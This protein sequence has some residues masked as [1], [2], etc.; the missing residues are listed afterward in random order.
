MK[1][2]IFV[3]SLTLASLTLFAQQN[4]GYTDKQSGY[5]T[6][7]FWNNWFLNVGGGPAF[8]WAGKGE[9]N[10]IDAFAKHI[11]WGATVS[12]GKWFTP[13]WGGRLTVQ[14]GMYH[15]FS[16]N[17]V[18]VLEGDPKHKVASD[19][20]L[21]IHADGL[22][23]FSN[24]VAGYK[25]NR[26][27]N[28]IPY[29]GVGIGGNEW[30]WHDD[31]NLDKCNKSFVPVV[32][33][34]NSFRLGKRVDFNVDISGQ[35]VQ[36]KWNSARFGQNAEVA[37][38][39]TGF[40]HQ[41]WDGILSVNFGFTFKLGKQDF[42]RGRVCPPV[43]NDSLL[44][45]NLTKKVNDLTAENN[46]LKNQLANQQPVAPV[47]ETPKP[48]TTKTSVSKI[49]AIPFE[50]NKFQVVDSKQKSAINDAV[51]FLKSNPDTDVRVVGYADK[52]TGTTAINNELSRKRADEVT[53]KLIS[54]GISKDRISTYW[55][56]DDVQ[57]YAENNQNRVVIITALDCVDCK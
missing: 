36:S 9:S 29:I 1:K 5:E 22:F 51:A 32:G 38:K 31:A 4:T 28:L 2:T 24:W 20:Y 23:N 27:Y 56:G 16:R 55:K 17:G 19:G 3:F 7:R 49:I 8:Y 50:L 6:N 48:T 41:D 37:Y 33:F 25:P 44:V 30:P 45:D 26:V 53:A 52:K 13:L 12:A 57:P 43:T 21:S 35:A 10:N 54:A 46:N 39:K 42:N 15:T 47:T 40:N 14:G 34:L 18:P 11:T